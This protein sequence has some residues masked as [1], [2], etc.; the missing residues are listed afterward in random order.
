M[1]LVKLGGLV[2]EAEWSE[3]FQRLKRVESDDRG[4]MIKQDLICLEHEKP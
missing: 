4:K 3:G 2:A 1:G